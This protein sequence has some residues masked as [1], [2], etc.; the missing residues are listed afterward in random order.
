LKRFIR[1]LYEYEQEKRIRNVGFVKVETGDEE[2]IVHMQGKGFHNSDD[3]KLA[4]Y[5]FYEKEGK[6]VAI[7]KENMEIGMPV[8]NHHM[9][10]T[11]ADTG[12]PENYP[13]VRGIIVETDSGRRFAVTWD[14]RPVDV[15][16]M[17]VFEKEASKPQQIGTK[18]TKIQRQ[19]LAK[20]PRCEWQLANN[21]FLV[22][23][24]QN[25]RHLVLIEDGN[26]RKLGVPGI[27]HINEAKAARAFGFDEFLPIEEADITLSSEEKHQD[28]PFGYWCR[29]VKQRSVHP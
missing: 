7:W 27:Y 25:Y 15:S 2:T 24:Y 5:L 22:H 12:V 13:K 8:L 21:R 9:R 23:G 3:R 20:L 14:D 28:E 19:D 29:T 11:D 18:L 6:V 17:R 10:Y 26:I 4:L 1:Y 16:R